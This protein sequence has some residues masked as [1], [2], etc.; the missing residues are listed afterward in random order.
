MNIMKTSLL[1]GSQ[2]LEWI[3]IEFL[4]FRIIQPHW[5][6]TRSRWFCHKLWIMRSVLS[7][8][9]ASQ[10]A[11]QFVFR[12]KAKRSAY[13]G[14]DF[15]CQLVLLIPTTTSAFELAKMT[16][17]IK[18]TY[19]FQALANKAIRTSITIINNLHGTCV[20]CKRRQPLVRKSQRV[21]NIC[22][23]HMILGPL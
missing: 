4:Q 12:L 18:L 7:L 19:F 21:C 9:V 6:T 11:W 16:A 22:R 10:H 13:A 15:A 20:Y 8:I 14:R 5:S 17:N 23:K 1:W 2:K 3:P